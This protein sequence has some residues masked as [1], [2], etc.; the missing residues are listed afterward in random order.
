M[1]YFKFFLKHTTLYYVLWTLLLIVLSCLPIFLFPPSDALRKVFSYVIL[2]IG[3]CAMQLPIARQL[4]QMNQLLIE[5]NNPVLYLQQTDFLFSG[6][7]LPAVLGRA[8]AG[9]TYCRVL[10][11][12]RVKAFCDLHQ[13]EDALSVFRFLQNNAKHMMPMHMAVIYHNLAFIYTQYNDFSLAEYY[14]EQERAA[15]QT[16]NPISKQR[17]IRV[18]M[19]LADTEANLASRQGD[20]ARA[21]PLYR[22]VEAQ[23]QGQKR[24]QPAQKAGIAYEIGEMY[25]RMGNFPEALPRLQFAAQYGGMTYCRAEAERLLSQIQM[26]R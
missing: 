23:M 2:C 8:G 19:L 5:Q 1:K 17:K 4:Q 7:D 10:M 24:L 12:N 25:F 9:G 22:Q 15:W 26:G 3:L 14:F 13:F 11:L 21:E 18:Q 6:M 20:F 16:V